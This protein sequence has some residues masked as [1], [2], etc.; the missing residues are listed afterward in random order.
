MRLKKK[1]GYGKN[2]VSGGKRNRATGE[3]IQQYLAKAGDGK[4]S[5]GKVG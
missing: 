4:K 3:V 5:T 1:E 2:G